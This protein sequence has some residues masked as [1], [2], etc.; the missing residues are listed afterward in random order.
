MEHLWTPWRMEYILSDKSNTTGC[1]FCKMI[2]DPPDR[3]RDNYLLYRGERACIILNLYPYNNGHMM[4]I[5]YMHISQLDE[6]PPDVQT[7]MMRLTSLG[8]R[9]LRQTMNPQGFNLGA[10]IGKTAGSGIDSHVHMHI[11]PRWA[12]D[13]NFMPVI[14]HTRVIPESLEQVYDRLKSALDKEDLAAS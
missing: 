8:I 11:V 4:V 7:E 3:D 6:L 10:N 14:A 5:P 2:A 1:V 13:T 9:L 12:G